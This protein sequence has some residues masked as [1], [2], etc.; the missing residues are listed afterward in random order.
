ME[1][2]SNKEKAKEIA[3]KL[4]HPNIDSFGDGDDE[5]DTRFYHVCKD[6]ALDAM[7]WK[8]QQLI[9]NLREV[10]SAHMHGGEIDEVLA[11][12]DE[13]MKGE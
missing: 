9:D 3:K 10:L 4:S 11:E 8:E 13:K 6:A 5:V 2:I 7:E 1:T 12:L